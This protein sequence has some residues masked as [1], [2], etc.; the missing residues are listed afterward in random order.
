MTTGDVAPEP[1]KVFVFPTLSVVPPDEVP[2]LMPNTV[3]L[4]PEED[5]PLMVLPLQ[6]PYI[7][8]RFAELNASD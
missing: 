3:E 8:V 5:K 4:A 7:V 6:L 2:T 1:D